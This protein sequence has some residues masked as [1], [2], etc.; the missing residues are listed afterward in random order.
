MELIVA[1]AHDVLIVAGAVCVLLLLVILWYVLG[2]VIQAK[3]MIRQTQHTYAQITTYLLEPFKYLSH[4]LFQEDEE[5]EVV[6]PSPRR[7][8][9]Q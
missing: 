7:K 3:R 1:V 5:E 4:W 2:M 9:K 6:S 8:R